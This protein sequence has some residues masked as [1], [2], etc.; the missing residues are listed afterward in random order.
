MMT[1]QWTLEHLVM[2]LDGQAIK[3]GVVHQTDSQD[4]WQ[5][6]TIPLDSQAKWQRMAIQ[7]HNQVTWQK[8]W[9]HFSLTHYTLR[10]KSHPI[11]KYCCSYLF[12]LPMLMLPIYYCY[13]TNSYCIGAFLSK[14]FMSND[15]LNNFSTIDWSFLTNYYQ[16]CFLTIGL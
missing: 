16:S 13:W 4:T 14:A 1:G 3:Q 10:L 7:L 5:R 11:S 2:Q 9:S 12:L 15:C 6:V 8:V